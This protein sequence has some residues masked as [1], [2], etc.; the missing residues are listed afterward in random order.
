V[1]TLT[2]RVDMVVQRVDALARMF[3][4]W[5]RRSGDGSGRS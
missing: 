3:E 5:L 1:D 4:E 2:Q